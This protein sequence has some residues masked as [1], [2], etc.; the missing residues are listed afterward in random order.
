MGVVGFHGEI[1]K[2]FHILGGSGLGKSL[3]TNDRFGPFFIENK[4]NCGF[5]AGVAL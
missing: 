4:G 5:F 2:D 1:G 3:P